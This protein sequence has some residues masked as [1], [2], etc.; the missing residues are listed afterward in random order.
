MSRLDAL[1][2]ALVRRTVLPVLVCTALLSPLAAAAQGW[3]EPPSRPGVVRPPDGQ[4]VRVATSIRATVEGRV[5]QIEVEEQFRNTGAGMAEGTYHYPL[6]GDAVF[7]SLSLWMGDTEMRGELMDAARARGIYE[8]IVR[9]RRDPALVTL[10]GH[11]LLRAQVFPIAPGETRKVVLRFTQVLD[12]QGDA[13][14]WRYA[15]GPD[16]R[17][18]A[19]PDI[20]V[21]LRDPSRFGRP[22][23]PTHSVQVSGADDRTVAVTD[24]ARGDVELFLPL[25]S[26]DAGLSV[27]THAPGGEDG[28][29]LLYVTPPEMSDAQRI[30]RDLTMVVDVSGSMSGPKLEQAKAAMLQVLG[31]LS[32]RDRFRLISFSS[33]VRSFRDGFTPAHAAALDSARRWTT[34]L[35]ADGGTNIEGALRE[36]MRRDRSAGAGDARLDVLVF[37]TD[38]VPSVGMTQPEQLAALAAQDAAGTRVFTVGIGTDVNTYLLERMAQDGRGAADFVPPNGNVEQTVG[39]LARRLR[40]PALVDLHVVSSPVRIVSLEPV[41]MPDLFAGQELVVLGRYQGSGSGPLVIEGSRDGRAVRVSTP[42]TFAARESDHEYVSTLWAARRIGA[43]TRTI[44]LEGATPARIEEI[45][46]LALRHGIV[47]EYTA[48][49]V[50][51][52]VVATGGVAPGRDEARRAAPPAAPARSQTGQVAFEAAQTSADFLNAVSV[53]GAR[54]V[55]ERAQDRGVPSGAAGAGQRIVGSRRFAQRGTQ[56][57]DVAQRTQRVVSVVAFSP[58]YF[59]LLQV[60]PELR[61]V[62]TLGDDVLV[63]GSRASIRIQRAG[64]HAL[65]GTDLQQ[66][67]KDFRGA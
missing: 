41:R 48:Y 32:D 59:A 10:A 31:T 11:Q 21:T 20:R 19:R 26:T 6:T 9:R 36:A 60:L 57:L 46:A 40:A 27:V 37:L 13:L 3:I 25:R 45:T 61:D 64:Q 54:R 5:A 50:Q 67:T 22:F 17:G 18:S 16:E 8:E 52:P 55:S 1:H 62:V 33:G 39:N 14:R 63:A 29:F 56:W 15:L 42:V 51:E 66:L 7:Q 44:R 53:S 58:A 28:Y 4:V 2:H 65:T 30:G 34:A 43:L 35:V 12:K 24:A 47:T 23:S 49:L 38:G